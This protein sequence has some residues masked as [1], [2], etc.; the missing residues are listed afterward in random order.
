MKRKTCI[1]AAV[2]AA[3]LAAA[4]AW[5]TARAVEPVTIVTMTAAAVTTAIGVQSAI[6]LHEWRAAKRFNEGAE[7]LGREAEGYRTAMREINAIKDAAW[8]ALVEA[9][10]TMPLVAEWEHPA[11]HLHREYHWSPLPERR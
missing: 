6:D 3:F 10:D 1:R 7:A 2:V 4:G 8:A 11:G 9:W 5:G